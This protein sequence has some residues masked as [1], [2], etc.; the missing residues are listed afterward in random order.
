M[1]NQKNYYCLMPKIIKHFKTIKRIK[2]TRYYNYYFWPGH[3]TNLF[4]IGVNF[5]PVIKDKKFLL[6]M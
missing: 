2:Q 1:K 4:L 6:L 5:T 3:S